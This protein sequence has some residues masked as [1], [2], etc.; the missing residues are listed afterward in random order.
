MKARLAVLKL[1]LE[2]GA[3]PTRKARGTQGTPLDAA[4]GRHQQKKYRVAWPD[5]IA[6]LQERSAKHSAT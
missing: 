5:A 3:D 6:V 2:R 1:L 4:H